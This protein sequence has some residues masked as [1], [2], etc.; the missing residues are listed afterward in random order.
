MTRV[1]GSLR[2][3]DLPLNEWILDILGGG[4][5]AALLRVELAAGP[6]P[7]R[8]GAGLASPAVRHPIGVPT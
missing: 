6:V 1:F 5:V 4:L 3:S 2:A 8:D 7:G